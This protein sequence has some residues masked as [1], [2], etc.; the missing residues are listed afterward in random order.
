MQ[1]STTVPYLYDK[2]NFGQ[3]PYLYTWIKNKNYDS[4]RF[5][6]HQITVFPAK[7]MERLIVSLLMM[8]KVANIIIST[9]STKY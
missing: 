8:V 2:K 5:F 7:Y 6:D 1:S 9:T 4:Y 3:N